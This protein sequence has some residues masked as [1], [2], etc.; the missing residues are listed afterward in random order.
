MKIAVPYENGQVF[1][2]FGHSAQFKIYNA[3][4][5]QVL[6]SEVISTNGRAMAHWSVF[7]F[8]MVRMSSSAAALA[9]VHRLP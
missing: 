5:G 9:P 7:W 1:Q 2:H 8:S 6:S 3:E 4:N